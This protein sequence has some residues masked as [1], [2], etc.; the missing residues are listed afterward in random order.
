V[1]SV[2]LDATPLLGKRTGVGVAVAGLIQALAALGRDGR[3]ATPGY[4]A[5]LEL[6]TFTMSWR[7]WPGWR[8]IGAQPGAAQLAA[9]LPAGVRAPAGPPMV[10]G[11]LQRSWR[12][13]DRPSAEWWTGRV[14]VVHGT[15]FVVP[16]TRRAARVVSVWDLTAV[17]YPQLCT[18]TTLRYPGLVRRA[19]AE[20]ATVH[21][22]ARS[23]G[24]EVVDLLG[25][26]P[27]QVRVIPLG[28]AVPPPSP[29][30][31][32]PAPSG[33][34]A[35]TSGPPYILGLGTLEPR[36]DFPGLI[37][38]FE[39]L[40]DQLPDSDVELWLA[41][42]NG[43]GSEAVQAAIDASAFRRRIRRLGWVED[44][45]ALVR[46]AAVFA[47]PSVYEGFG[48]PPLEAMALGVPVVA[49]AVGSLPEVLGDGAVLVP[50]S[51]PD[52]LASA[53][54]DALS[55]DEAARRA[56]MAAGRRQAARYTWQATARAMA[57]LYRELAPR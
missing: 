2:A 23:I 55:E 30:S 26:D 16:P 40:A 42:P 14:D 13:A 56:R 20:G 11:A 36:K 5:E 3:G 47:Y 8:G 48:L 49:T 7:A 19:A 15:N 39:R 12:Y 35:A 18:P 9:A 6:R 29:P 45:A 51:D 34:A 50:P 57:G 32:S 4:P 28:L 44:A 27:A 31:S 22:A 25:A 37:R 43:W 41:G 10:A 54:M 52:A 38:A 33:A 21:V 17:R 53:L 1:P 24:D 46:R